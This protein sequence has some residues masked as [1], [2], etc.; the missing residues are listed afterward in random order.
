MRYTFETAEQYI[1]AWKH[2]III[3]INFS[4]SFNG[5]WV[6]SDEFGELDEQTFA[7]IKNGFMYS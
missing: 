2:C 3:G 6:E 5:R 7:N 1:N 4:Y